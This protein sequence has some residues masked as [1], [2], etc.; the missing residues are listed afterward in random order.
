MRKITASILFVTVIMLLAACNKGVSYAERVETE[1]KRIKQFLHEQDIV[2]LDTY[3]SNGVFESNQYYLDESGVYINVVDSGN[4]KRASSYD[5]VYFRFNEVMELPT[6][7]SDTIR[8]WVTNP[9]LQPMD[10]IYGVSGSYVDSEGTRHS[11]SYQTLSEGITI[12][13]QY[14]GEDAVVNILVPFKIGSAY[15]T[16]YFTTLYYKRLR[17]TKIVSTQ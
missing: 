12:P 13:L 2:V 10:F 17:Y 6:S 3:P 4:G 1:K 14:V 9:G 8:P 16:T 7:E 5:K 11:Y 15:Q